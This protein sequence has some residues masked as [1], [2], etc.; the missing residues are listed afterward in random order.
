MKYLALIPT[1][2]GATK[3]LQK[4][5]RNFLKLYNFLEICETILIL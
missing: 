2:D 4:K 5:C 1:F 3:D